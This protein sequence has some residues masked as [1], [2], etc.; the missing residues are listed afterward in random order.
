MSRFITAINCIDGRVQLPVIDYM[1]QTHGAKYVDMITAPGV[2][3][4]LAD[5]TD[6]E[7]ESIKRSVRTSLTAHASTFV[8]IVGH[9]DCA[10]NATGEEIQRKHIRKALKRV[11]SWE[12]TVEVLGLWLDENFKVHEIRLRTMESGGYV[13]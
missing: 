4:L 11:N 7:V 9:H 5:G 1:S 2:D 10:G 6:D 3:R 12:L 13:T 8:A